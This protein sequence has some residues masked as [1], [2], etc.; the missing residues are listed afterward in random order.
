MPLRIKNSCF[1][2]DFSFPYR[3]LLRNWDIKGLENSAERS[4]L[5]FP[6]PRVFGI[7]TLVNIT[8][9]RVNIR[10]LL[11]LQYSRTY[12][13]WIK[14][15]IRIKPTNILARRFS[16]PFVNCIGLSLIRFAYPISQL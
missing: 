6:E 2:Q 5:P 16:K 12:K 9:Y 13:V 3:R 10:M 11:K 7:R 15:V 8:M 4:L 14:Q 1:L